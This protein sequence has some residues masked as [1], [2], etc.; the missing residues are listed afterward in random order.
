[1]HHQFNQKGVHLDG[2]EANVFI[3]KH[4]YI[5]FNEKALWHIWHMLILWYMLNKNKS[6]KDGQP[7]LFNRSKILIWTHPIHD[8]NRHLRILYMASNSCQ[9][10][11][12]ISGIPCHN[13]TLQCMYNIKITYRMSQFSGALNVECQNFVHYSIFVK[14]TNR[15]IHQ[16]NVALGILAS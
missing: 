15:E 1:M 9:N 3:D 10:P 11:I 4:V 6:K 16:V 13:G 7:C 5:L 14:S 2:H 12:L 8:H